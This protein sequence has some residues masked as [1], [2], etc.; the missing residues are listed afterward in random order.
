[1]DLSLYARIATQQSL[2]SLCLEKSFTIGEY[3]KLSFYLDAF[4]LGGRSGVNVS[5]NP[6]PRL[7]FDEDPPEYSLSGSSYGDINSIYGVR[8]FRFGAKFAF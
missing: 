1:M 8:S 3:G 5:D 6:Y 7:Y 4:N 2:H